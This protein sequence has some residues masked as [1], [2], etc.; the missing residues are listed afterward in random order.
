MEHILKLGDQLIETYQGISFVQS[1]IMAHENVKNEILNCYINLETFYFNGN[2]IL[3]FSDVSWEDFRIRDIVHMDMYKLENIK[4]NN[5]TNFIKERIDRNE[6]ILIFKID[7]YYLPY[8]KSFRKT[9]YI[10]DTYIYG[11]DKEE[12]LVMAYSNNKLQKLRVHEK[13]IKKGIYKAWV[14][15]KEIFI[16][17]LHVNK[18]IKIEL[19]IEKIIQSLKYYLNCMNNNGEMS[20]EKIYGIGVNKVLKKYLAEKKNKNIDLRL[21]RQLYEHKKIMRIRLSEIKKIIRINDELIKEVVDLESM[22]ENILNMALK[23]NLT[24]NAG[25][26]N[27]IITILDNIEDKEM[28]FIDN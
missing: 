11:Y 25:I 16:C 17:T 14:K 6:Y 3:V 8:S 18:F 10:H 12:L 26:I 21:F 20:E 2:L 9:H 1:I 23:Y 13:A 15:N 4:K 19:D 28:V 27:R 22:T 7:E 5:I 24:G